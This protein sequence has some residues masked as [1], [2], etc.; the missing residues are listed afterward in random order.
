MKILSISLIILFCVILLLP[1]KVLS[2]AKKLDDIRFINTE[3]TLGKTKQE[4]T[5]TIGSPHDLGL[6]DINTV[7]NKQQ[8]SITG[9]SWIYSVVFEKGEIFL[10]ICFV[11]SRVV[12]EQRIIKN[13]SQTQIQYKSMIEKVDHKLLDRLLIEKRSPSIEWVDPNG[14]GV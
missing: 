10:S 7:L 2:G 9:E 3:E 14:V 4:I 13:I 8:V 5:K 1:E 11:H 6:C 12:A